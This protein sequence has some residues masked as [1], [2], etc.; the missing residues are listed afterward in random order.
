M[1]K[2]ILAVFMTMLVFCGVIAVGAQAGSTTY[3]CTTGSGTDTIISL[4]E[5]GNYTVLKPGDVIEFSNQAKTTIN[6]YADADLLASTAVGSDG[7]SLI[8]NANWAFQDVENLASSANKFK[9]FKQEYTRAQFKSKS[10]TV[11]GIGDTGN[12]DTGSWTA[13]DAAGTEL[14]SQA[15]DFALTIDGNAVEFVGWVVYDYSVKSSAISLNLYA[16]WAKTDDEP[17]TGEDVSDGDEEVTDI[18]DSTDTTDEEPDIVDRLNGYIDNVSGLFA[19]I[20]SLLGTLLS[21]IFENIKLIL[22]T[23]FGFTEVL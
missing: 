16:L 10:Y 8:T 15:I 20:Y 23:W 13:L 22:Y 3:T 14:G 18:T 2:K 6:F 19:T 9:A 12:N 5:T 17:S 1:A 4:K 11:I 21:G 7:A